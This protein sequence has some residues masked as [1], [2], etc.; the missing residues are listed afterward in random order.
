[1]RSND[2][3]LVQLSAK[4]SS[5]IK[6]KTY[7]YAADDCRHSRSITNFRCQRR[8][9]D[10]D[11]DIDIGAIDSQYPLTHPLTHIDS[12]GMILGTTRQ[13]STT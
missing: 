9:Q 6:I 13:L 11:I 3:N 12:G 5:K 7:I 1:M 10:I 4:L 8:Q 2:E